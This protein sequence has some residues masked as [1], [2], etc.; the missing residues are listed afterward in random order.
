MATVQW[1]H[2]WVTLINTWKLNCKVPQC[3]VMDRNSSSLDKLKPFSLSKS[4]NV[5][6]H[7]VNYTPKDFSI[8]FNS[9][10]AAVRLTVDNQAWKTL[11][12][13]EYGFLTRVS[14]NPT[15]P[16]CGRLSGFSFWRKCWETFFSLHRIISDH[17]SGNSQPA[18]TWLKNLSNSKVTKGNER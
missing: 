16:L 10:D 18:F 5:F 15:G 11:I 14:L 1:P 6:C 4:Y 3:L 12:V 17:K 8:S 7:E 9:W 13:C 2:S